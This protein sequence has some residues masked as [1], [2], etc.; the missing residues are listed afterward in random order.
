VTRR[1]W[2]ANMIP[3]TFFAAKDRYRVGARSLRERK[4]LGDHGQVLY[5]TCLVSVSGGLVSKACESGYWHL[6]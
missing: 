4:I 2:G 6:E 3:K 5:P 1:T